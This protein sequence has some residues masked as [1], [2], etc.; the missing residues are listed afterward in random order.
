MSNKSKAFES[1][2]SEQ[3]G[4][5]TKASIRTRDMRSKMA[6]FTSMQ[7]EME[8]LPESYPSVACY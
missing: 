8:L 4:V 1:W 5:M 6:L 3:D 7:L 2:S